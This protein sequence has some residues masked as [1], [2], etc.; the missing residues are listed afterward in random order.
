[1][2][3]IYRLVR[4]NL[5]LLASRQNYQ[6]AERNAFFGRHLRTELATNVKS[7]CVTCKVQKKLILLTF[8]LEDDFNTTFVSFWTFKCM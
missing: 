1:M 3:P 5:F 2:F 8:A 7:S 6:E 4:H